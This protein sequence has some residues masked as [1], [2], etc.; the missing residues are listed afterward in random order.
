[1]AK[2]DQDVDTLV[3]NA[4]EFIEENVVSDTEYTQQQ[5]VDMLEELAGRCEERARIIRGEM[6]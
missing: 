6:G 2:T 5:T 3:E 4:Y 1:M